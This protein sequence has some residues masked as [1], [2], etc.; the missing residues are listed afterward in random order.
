VKVPDRVFNW[1]PWSLIEDE[2]SYDG[3]ELFG[4]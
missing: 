4:K 3:I 2:I 1:Y